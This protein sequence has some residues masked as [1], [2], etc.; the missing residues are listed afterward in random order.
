M[1]E[2]RDKGIQ[3]ENTQ[4]LPKLL[5]FYSG[6]PVVECN[7]IFI[8]FISNVYLQQLNVNSLFLKYIFSLSVVSKGLVKAE[9]GKDGREC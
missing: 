3:T 7:V 4:K 1:Q 6:F 8:K 9:P 2:V 5:V